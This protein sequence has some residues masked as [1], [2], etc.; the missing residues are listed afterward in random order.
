MLYFVVVIFSHSRHITYF[1]R[2]WITV[3]QLILFANRIRDSKNMG[4]KDICLIFSKGMESLWT[5]SK[6]VETRPKYLLCSLVACGLYHSVELMRA[7]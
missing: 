3:Y 6:Q 1:S 7:F 5:S 4:E 2:W